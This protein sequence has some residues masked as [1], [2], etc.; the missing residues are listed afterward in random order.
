MSVVGG[1]GVRM[2]LSQEDRQKYDDYTVVRLQ[3]YG[4]L[5]RVDTR[6]SVDSPLRTQ[7]FY[8]DRFYQSAA[9]QLDVLLPALTRPE[10]LATNTLRTITLRIQP[11]V[12]DRAAIVYLKRNGLV[13]G[14]DVIK[15]SIAGWIKK[16]EEAFMEAMDGIIGRLALEGYVTVEEWWDVKRVT[17][18]T[19]NS[20]DAT[21]SLIGGSGVLVPLLPNEQISY[22]QRIISYLRGAYGVIERHNTSYPPTSPLR[23]EAFFELVC[24]KKFKC[25]L[26]QLDVLLPAL[27][28]HPGVLPPTTS[29]RSITLRLEL[30]DPDKAW[31][32]SDQISG[33]IAHGREV[34]FKAFD[35]WFTS[36]LTKKAQP[37]MFDVADA[38]IGQIIQD[39][40]LIVKERWDLRRGLWV[41]TV[42]Y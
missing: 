6:Y 3:S 18:P 11:V 38:I 12:P 42:R 39:G 17:Q 41:L 20:T 13:E 9:S 22:E 8:S 35:D 26:V 7:T 21:H 24:M 16:A 14:R 19:E 23:M 1:S 2:P 5:S 27:L 34:L 40:L 31:V 33:N 4:T 10:V 15:R 29:L 37:A 25:L 36:Q 30:P 32:Q 28:P